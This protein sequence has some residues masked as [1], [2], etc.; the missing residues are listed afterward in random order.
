MEIYD[1]IIFLF[2]YLFI[3]L[4]LYYLFIKSYGCYTNQQQNAIHQEPNNRCDNSNLK[5]LKSLI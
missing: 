1:L 3:N 5:Y 2:I 4:L